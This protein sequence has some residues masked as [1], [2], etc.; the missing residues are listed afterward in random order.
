MVGVIHDF[1]PNGGEISRD[2][3]VEVACAFSTAASK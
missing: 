3:I 2:T 1:N